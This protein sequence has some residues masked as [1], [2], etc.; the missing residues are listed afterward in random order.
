MDAY[1]RETEFWRENGPSAS[2]EIMLYF[3]ENAVSVRHTQTQILYTFLIPIFLLHVY[4]VNP[5][6]GSLLNYE[7]T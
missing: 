4:F 7:Y 3:T 2:Q 5:S 6:R 1:V